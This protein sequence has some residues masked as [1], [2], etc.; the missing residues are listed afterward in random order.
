MTKAEAIEEAKKRG[1]KWVAMDASGEWW[2]YEHNPKTIA[3]CFCSDG[4][5]RSLGKN[6]PSW[7]DSLTE[8]L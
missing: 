6:E 2:G 1:L 4:G 5:A 3:S 7:R 8:V